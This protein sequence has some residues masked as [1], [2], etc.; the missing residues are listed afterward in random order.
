MIRLPRMWAQMHSGAWLRLLA[1]NRF[2]IDPDLRAGALLATV[3]GLGATALGR[4]QGLLCGRTL[5][6]TRVE[7]PLFI[8]GHWRSGTTFLHEV[9]ASDGRWAVPTFLTCTFAQ[10]VL[11]T[12]PLLERT[13]RLPPGLKRPMDN[14]AMEPHSPWEDEFALVALG[15]PSPYS[16]YAFPNRPRPYP[17]YL[18]LEGLTPVALASWKAAFMGFLKV[19]TRLEGRPA[20]LKSP[21][22][23]ARLKVLAP[24]FPRARYVYLV[25]H[26]YDVIPSMIR[27]MAALNGALGLQRPANRD[28]EERVLEDYATLLRCLEEG[29]PLVP[30]ERFHEVRFEDLAADPMG[31]IERLYAAL[32]L[33]GFESARERLAARVAAMSGSRPAARPPLRDDLAARLREVCAATFERYGYSP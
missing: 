1:R 8:L 5:A 32:G 30:A 12:R 6:A 26:P 18:G 23:T 22:H 13:V 29:R 4:V 7:D 15:Q 24:M 17:E 9:L 3:Q 16:Q 27:T 28:L 10:H 11:L 33:D 31:R 2:E 21:T 19:L 25:R 14:I 20:L